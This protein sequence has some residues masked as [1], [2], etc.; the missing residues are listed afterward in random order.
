MFFIT[1]IQVTITSYTGVT[2]KVLIFQ[3]ATV[4]PTEYLKCYQVL[5]WFEVIG[6]VEFCFQF[7]ILTITYVTSVYPKIHIGSYRAEMSI[8][9]FSFPIVWKDDFFA[10]RSYVVIGGRNFGRIIIKLTSP[11]ISDV[12]INRITI[13]V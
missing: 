6:K 1:C 4:T 7:T 12:Y 3:I 5:A 13:S 10:V 8:Y 2:E 11:G 9:F